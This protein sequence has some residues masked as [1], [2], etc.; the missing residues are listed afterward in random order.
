MKQ[1]K[2]IDPVHKDAEGFWFYNEVWADRYG[3]YETE[4]IARSELQRHCDTVLRDKDDTENR[5]K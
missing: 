3:P 4:E 2:L 1:Y 5:S